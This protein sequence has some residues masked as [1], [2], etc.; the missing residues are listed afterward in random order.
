MPGTAMLG[1]AAYSG[2]QGDTTTE[3]T[4]RNL[5]PETALQRQAEEGT[6]K[7]Y[8][9]LQGEVN[10]GP[11]QQDISDYMGNSRSLEALL[12]Q[13]SQNGGMPSSSD[14]SQAN[15][16]ASQAYA[17]QQTAL[18]Q[19][20]QTQLQQGQNS[21][22]LMGRD[23][24]DPTLQGALRSAQMLQQQQLSANQG[25]FGTQL[26][27]QLPQQRLSYAQQQNTMMG[28]LASQALQ[29]RSALLA[30]GN[31]ILGG[32]QNYQIGAS[33]STTS[34]HSGGGLAGAFNG[35]LYTGGKIGSMIGSS[36]MSSGGGAAGANPA[37]GKAAS[38]GGSGVA[39]P[40]ALSGYNYSQSPSNF[41]GVG[42]GAQYGGTPSYNSAPSSYQM[43]SQFTG[44]PGAPNM[45][46]GSGY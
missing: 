38:Q 4:N 14:F 23:G 18:N 22:A 26:A 11:G 8:A 7:D 34:N 33:G 31:S 44:A 35:M 10:A 30:Q 3:S 6:S 24:N 2:A 20:F 45:F 37:T 21:A 41:F 43:G 29:N 17:G 12:G 36:G 32:Q 42:S 25:A 28:G 39:G 40:G 46:S 15:G 19:S 13:Y 27:M 5:G 1:M 16:L 9:A